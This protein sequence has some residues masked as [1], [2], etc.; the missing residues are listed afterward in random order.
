MKIRNRQHFGQAETEGTPMATPRMKKNNSIGAPPPAAE[1]VLEGDYKDKEL[2][3]ISQ[4][5]LD[6]FTRV[7]DLDSLPQYITMDKFQGKMKV[8]RENVSTSP[9]GRHLGTY[10]V[11]FQPIDFRL[12]E[13]TTESPQHKQQAIARV[14]VQMLNYAIKQRHAYD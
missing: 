3:S 4:L 6:N 1:L 2:D 10:K 11:L 5:M 7:T 9:S 12:N 13:T 8:W 14:H